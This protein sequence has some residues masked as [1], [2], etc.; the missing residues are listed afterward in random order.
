[1]NAAIEF[2]IPYETK[3]KKNMTYDG[4]VGKD[5]RY[6]GS[7]AAD[8]DTLVITAHNGVTLEITF[9]S[10]DKQYSLSELVLKAN[11]KHFKDGID[12]NIE[13]NYTN[14]K[15]FQLNQGDYYT[16]KSETTL[17]LT[18]DVKVSITNLELEAFR[19][20]NTTDISGKRVICPKDQTTNSIVP[21]AV[22]AA[23][24]GL[25]VVVLIAYLI[26]RKRSRRGYESV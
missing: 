9:K 8:T 11:S 3:G 4:V 1:M 26:G 16:C 19:N 12:K 15:K 13:S 10:K 14:T 20:S 24:A 22:G 18:H 6:T 25:V 17:Q 2:H 5:P 7:C 23:L 21:I